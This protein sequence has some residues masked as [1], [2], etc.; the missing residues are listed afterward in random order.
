ML[1]I[2]SGMDRRGCHPDLRFD[3]YRGGRERW[4]RLLV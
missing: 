3:R 1:V 2:A 4:T